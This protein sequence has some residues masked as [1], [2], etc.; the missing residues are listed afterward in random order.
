MAARR[1]QINPHFTKNSVPCQEFRARFRAE[2]GN[3]RFDQRGYRKREESKRAPLVPA[4]PSP[5]SCG[6]AEA[7]AA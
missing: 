1:Q 6:H 3:T 4:F 7:R 5:R 2:L